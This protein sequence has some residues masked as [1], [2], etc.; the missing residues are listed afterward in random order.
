MNFN[1]KLEELLDFS[2]EDYPNSAYSLIEERAVPYSK[3]PEFFSYRYPEKPIYGL[4]EKIEVVTSEWMNNRHIYLIAES[5]NI[6][7]IDILT[8]L[9][10]NLTDIYGADEKRNLWLS[11]EEVEE[12]RLNQ[13]KGRHWSFPKNEELRD[14]SIYL[15][16]S[17]L[18]LAIYERGDL[19]DFD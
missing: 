17:R 10:D 5:F 6:S 1:Q 4:F 11:G 9:V 7:Q 13:W 8:Q 15:E 14:A 19:L 2:L 12:I 16:G 18:S 3:F